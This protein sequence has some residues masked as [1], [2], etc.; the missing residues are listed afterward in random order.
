MLDNLTVYVVSIDGRTVAA[1]RDGWSLL[2]PLKAGPHK[3]RVAFVRGVFS[4]QADLEFTAKAEAAYQIKFATD[5]QFLGKNTYCEFWIEDTATGR[6]MV[7]PNR[8]PL[9]RAEREK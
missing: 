3:L 5:A 6:A 7:A 1:G 9:V 2:L 8:V 4:A